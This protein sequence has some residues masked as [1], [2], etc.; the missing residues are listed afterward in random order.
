MLEFQEGIT[1]EETARKEPEEAVC[2]Q[3]TILYNMVLE[4]VIL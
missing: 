3:V 2:M 1:A 4:L